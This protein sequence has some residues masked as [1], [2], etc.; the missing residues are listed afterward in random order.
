MT[1]QSV[2]AGMLFVEAP[3]S[4]DDM[5]AIV[6]R[7]GAP[8]PLMANMIEGGKTPL[9]TVD[10]VQAMGFSL[11]I[12][13]GGL[14]RAFAH[15]AEEYLASLRQHGT[16]RPFRDRMLGFA[17]LNDVVGTR[18]ML[19]TGRRYDGGTPEDARE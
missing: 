5:T 16:N 18:D 8:V 14:V 17:R 2:V 19:E 11:V 13:P 12:F 15:M 3:Q 4:I 9:F 6:D 10:D 1:Y 7:L